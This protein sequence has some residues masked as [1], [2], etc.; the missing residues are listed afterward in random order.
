MAVTVNGTATTSNIGGSTIGS[1]VP[2]TFTYTAPAGTVGLVIVEGSISSANAAPTAVSYNGAAATLITNTFSINPNS[3]GGGAQSSMWYLAS[4]A[5]GSA[6]TVSITYTQS[7][8]GG[9]V[10][11]LIPLLGVSSIAPFQT[12][13]TANNS[14]TGLTVTTAPLITPP[15]ATANDLYIGVVS[16]EEDTA[17]T[18]TVNGGTQLTNTTSRGSL[19]VGT[20]SL[21]GNGGSLGWTLSVANPWVMSAVA[22]LAPTSGGGTAPIAW[23]T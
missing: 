9:A 15:V 5:T 14:N 19:I 23:I 21:A 16:V 12:T 17:A 18:A 3:G 10:A 6:L 7:V 8:N 11:V 1:G 4:P 20:S 22:F 2:T 13:T